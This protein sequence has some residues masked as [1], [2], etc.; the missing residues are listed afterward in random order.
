MFIYDFKRNEITNQA[1]NTKGTQR[2]INKNPY[3][4]I[5]NKMIARSFC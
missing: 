3:F 4:A 2:C 5:K 1:H